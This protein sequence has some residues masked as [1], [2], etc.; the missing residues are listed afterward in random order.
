MIGNVVKKLGVTL[1]VKVMGVELIKNYPSFVVIKLNEII[2][3]PNGSVGELLKGEK[4]KVKAIR[5]VGG[6]KATI[7]DI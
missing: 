1:G 7:W 2:M 6:L 5:D 3:G 4:I